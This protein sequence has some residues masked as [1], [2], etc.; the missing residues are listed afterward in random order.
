MI[1]VGVAGLGRMGMLHLL[2]CL[3]I[4]GVTVVA[5]ADASK[6]SLK[7]AMS[8]GIKN[9]YEDY[10]DLLSHHSEIDAV[11]IS[12]PNFLHLE[13]IRL[14]LEAGMNVFVEK[15][16]ANTV[17]ECREIVSA[18]NKAER[19]FM[20]G[21]VMRFTEAIEKMKSS[22]DSGLIGNIEVVTIE[23]VINGPFSHPRKP[24][25]ISDWWFDSRKSGGGVLID[26]GYHLIDL[27]RFFAG[28]AKVIFSCLDHKFNLPVEDSAI[29]LLG[30]DNSSTKGIINA[31]WYQQTVF[32]K[33]NFRTILHGTA[34]YISSDDLVPHNLYLHAAKEGTKN[35][36][37]RMV[38]KKIRPLSYTYFNEPFY[39]EL[40]H[41]FECVRTNSKPLISAEDGLKTI[42]VIQE[43]YAKFGNI[44]A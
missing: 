2:N 6:K 30:S 16:L 21:H 9:V 28:D 18:A 35:I 17:E 1:K 4:D 38:G 26:L 24:A 34:G 40:T 43:A 3:K 12:L 23:E 44:K 10:H 11:V 39:K 5:A 32:P 37:R 7:K 20:I 15:P 31:G 27:Y 19:T 41:F 14:S 33:Y 42:E 36:L 22:T 29:V 25:P 13:S 8:L